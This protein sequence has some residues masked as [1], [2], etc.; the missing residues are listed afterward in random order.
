MNTDVG[1]D[2]PNNPLVND[3]KYKLNNFYTVFV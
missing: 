1:T 2:L 3:L